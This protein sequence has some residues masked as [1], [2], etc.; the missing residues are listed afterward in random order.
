MKKSDINYSQLTIILIAIIAITI[1]I[2]LFTF[3]PSYAQK[4][5][6]SRNDVKSDTTKKSEYHYKTITIDANG[7]KKVVEKVSD[8][9]IDDK[10]LEED[11]DNSGINISIN[12]DDK[13]KNGVKVYTHINIDTAGINKIIRDVVIASRDIGDAI[14]NIDTKEIEKDVA[15]AQK[16]INSVDW[17]AV[18]AEINNAIAEIYKNVTDPKL[19]KEIKVEINNAIEEE[20]RARREGDEA[21][22]RSDEAR[23]RGDEARERG[24][25]ARKR[26]DEARKRGEEAR[27]RG[28]EARRR[29]E[30]ARMDATENVDNMLKKME[31]DGLIDR[32]KGYKIQKKNNALYI[33]GK[34]QP[35][36]IYNKYSHFLIG[37][38]VT[39]NWKTEEDN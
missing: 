11:D 1:S 32:S 5:K 2:G 6:A 22:E 24:E 16:E 17:D 19:R 4:S 13:T 29:G 27:E 18:N 25:E 33:N 21:H 9:P 28:E 23:K 12:D 14:K 8:K 37:Q 38:K 3:T 36:A 34:K 10:M 35:E 15:D 20:K 31:D 30:V 7:R 26:G 39:I